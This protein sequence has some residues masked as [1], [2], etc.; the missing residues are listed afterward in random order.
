MKRL[1]TFLL[2]VALLLGCGSVAMADGPGRFSHFLALNPWED[3]TF[4][5]ISPRDWY[6]D[7]VVTAYRM[8]LVGGKG[9]AIFDPYGEIT[10][11]ETIKIAASIQSLY[12]TADTKFEESDPWYRS[13]V[14]YAL[15]YDVISGEYGDYE[16]PATRAEF[17]TILF[18]A[19]PIRYFES[20]NTV[21]NGAIPD[22]AFSESY[23][24][25]VYRMYRAGVLTGDANG[26]F[27]P[28]DHISRCEAVAIV[29]RIML[30]RDRKSVTMTTQLG[31]VL[32]GEEIF[33]KCSPAVFY[34]EMY[35][36]K[37]QKTA[38]G[39]GFFINSNGTAVTCWHVL[40]NGVSAKI[41]IASTGKIYDVVGVYDYDVDNDWAVIQ[42]D[43]SGFDYLEI[44]DA[45]TDVG[46]ATV[47]AMGSPLGL[48]NTIT[49]G[50][51]CNPTR[52]EDMTR[53]IL[54]S[55][56]ISS[57]S[58]GGA[59]INKYGQA[60]GITAATYIY[61]QNLNLAINMSYIDEAHRTAVRSLSEIH[62][63]IMEEAMAKQGKLHD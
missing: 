46:G 44:G 58:S 45:K 52:I 60:I 5:D 28:N 51:I 54:F 4:A 40:E 33:A 43:G 47:Y 36:E 38:N 30:E 21:E 35:N 14:D 63:K 16:R 23:A 34:I 8:G 42:V 22:V 41:S 17:A 10:L 15:T 53:Y 13:Y 18:H 20:V 27:H 32:S 62:E 49:Q 59:L 50:L 39:S 3:G 31:D 7:N 26:A 56:A 48:Q 2:C 55:A 11:A 29:G 1:F 37:G 19:L 9:E 12:R 57:G 6:Y 25:A 61:G 24:G